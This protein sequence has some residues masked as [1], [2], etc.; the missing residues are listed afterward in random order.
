MVK[1]A[2]DEDRLVLAVAERQVIEAH[3]L[4]SEACFDLIM[5]GSDLTL[6]AAEELRK[7]EE[8][9]GYAPYS[10]LTPQSEWLGGNI[11]ENANRYRWP[12]GLGGR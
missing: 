9:V 10:L 1:L 11:E 8:I 3:R 12:H 7:I 6:A 5:H 2:T 4:I